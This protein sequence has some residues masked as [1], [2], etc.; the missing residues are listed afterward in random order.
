MKTSFV[1]LYVRLL[2][3]LPSLLICTI[4]S[5]VAVLPSSNSKATASS[6][7]SLPVPILFQ[8]ILIYLNFY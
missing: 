8:L 1:L 7:C 4:V 6:L 5:Q 2:Y 3:S